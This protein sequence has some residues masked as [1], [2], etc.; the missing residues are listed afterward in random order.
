MPAT[1]LLINDAKHVI[2]GR[3]EK[4]KMSICPEEK[5]IYRF[6][7]HIRYPE[8]YPSRGGILPHHKTKY[9]LQSSP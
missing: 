2:E 7:L 4:I 3:R 5:L 1:L 8:L 6:N 9:L